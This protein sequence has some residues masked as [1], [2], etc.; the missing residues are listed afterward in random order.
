VTALAWLL[1]WSAVLIVPLGRPRPPAG[2]A[3]GNTGSARGNTG[4]AGGGTGSGRGNTG[5][6]RDDAGLALALDLTAA[7]LRSGRPLS[8][9]LA[10]AAPAVASP[11]ADLLTRAAALD[12]LGAPPDEVWSG[13]PR[14]GPLG[15]LVRVATRSAA[16]GLKLATG[17]ERLAAELRAERT[18]A[19][20]VRAHR[21]AVWAVAPL[22]ACFLPSFVC[23]G[24]I[25]V[26]VGVARQVVGGLRG[27]F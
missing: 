27:G 15:E 25:P 3:G 16:S 5:S 23:L 7:G 11:V 20:A 10:L 26:V 24:V 21:A 8:A 4:S 17:L 12:R 2:A 6:A 9:A 19:A 14:D 1:F 22:A 13:L 18:A